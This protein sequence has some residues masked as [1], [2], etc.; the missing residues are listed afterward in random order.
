M[1]IPA[2]TVAAQGMGLPDA[3]PHA[4]CVMGLHLLKVDT[5]LISAPLVGALLLMLLTQVL[6]LLG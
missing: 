6:L 4:L 5:V 3:E 2:L 1:S